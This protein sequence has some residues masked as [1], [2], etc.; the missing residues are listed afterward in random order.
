[1]IK[2]KCKDCRWELETKQEY[3][4]GAKDQVMSHVLKYN[5]TVKASTNYKLVFLL[6]AILIIGIA[7]VLLGVRMLQ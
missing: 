6:W 7:I 3:Y 4:E 5:H 2:F 1:M